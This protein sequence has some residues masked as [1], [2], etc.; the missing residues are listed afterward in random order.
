MFIFLFE[1][2][3]TNYF[4]RQ[5]GTKF[6]TC[7]PTILIVYY[8]F[9]NPL[10]YLITLI[11]QSH[12]VIC[13]IRQKYSAHFI[14]NKGI[15]NKVLHKGFF[16]RH[17][18]CYPREVM[19]KIT[20]LFNSSFAITHSETI[21]HFIHNRDCCRNSFVRQQI[22]KQTTPFVFLHFSVA[23]PNLTFTLKAIFLDKVLL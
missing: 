6:S 20:K 22:T 23:K 4:L 2:Q 19:H 16:I 12:I 18:V 7:S 5:D 21:P 11:N 14:R 13:I 8:K 3:R 1:F 9:D 15:L 10:S 17:L